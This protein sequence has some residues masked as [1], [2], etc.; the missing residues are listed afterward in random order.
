MLNSACKRSDL[1]IRSQVV[2]C[3]SVHFTVV[4]LCLCLDP[5]CSYSI[6]CFYIA[7]APS[8]FGFA[9]VAVVSLAPILHQSVEMSGSSSPGAVQGSSRGSSE[10]VDILTRK[11]FRK[12][13]VDR[14]IAAEVAETCAVDLL[15]FGTGSAPVGA[16]AS[17]LE[18]K[19][20]LAILLAPERGGRCH[21]QGDL[22]ACDDTPSEAH[23]EEMSSG[24]RKLGSAEGKVAN[25][26]PQQ[27]SFGVPISSEGVCAQF[28]A[29]PA[30]NRKS[31]SLVSLSGV[32]A[33]CPCV[34]SL[35]CVLVLC[36]C[37]VSLSGVLVLCPRLVSLSCVLVL[38]PRVVSLCRLLV[39]CPCLVS[40]CGVLILCPCVMS[41]SCVLVLFPRLVSLSCVLVSCLCLVSLSGVLVW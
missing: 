36:P 21:F 12:P 13:G 40:L 17:D 7:Y 30:Q 20:A 5:R 14:C 10:S 34:V 38:R 4:V 6:L 29:G 39:W 2:I 28:L 22:V 23:G 19:S 41:S 37:L 26:V 35:S 31:V 16:S 27:R 25:F 18:Y 8:A 9:H 3:R 1:A 32:L 11:V 33:L 24:K 15:S